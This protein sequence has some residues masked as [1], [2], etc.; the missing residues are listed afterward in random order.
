M[1]TTLP[2]Q[3]PS[4]QSNRQGAIRAG[5]YARV[6]TNDGR[7]DAEV[8]LS[9]LRTYSR[10]RGFAIQYEYIDHISGACEDRS[11][12]HQL[13]ADARQ[14]KLDAVLVW[15]FDRFARSTKALVLALEEFNTLG[16]DFVSYTEQID[17]TTPMGKAMFTMVSA[18]AEFERSLIRERV[19]AGLQRARE[20]GVKLGRPRVGFDMVKALQ[21]RSDGM[22][23]RN[24]A[25][26]LGISYTSVRRYLKGVS[27]TSLQ[28]PAYSVS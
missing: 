18:M 8:Q 25:K 6:S 27:K 20:R 17:T 21:L 23:L 7:Q 11:G 1:S 28:E 22:S 13:I 14:R 5:L 26:E 15:K 4:G 12:Y 16:V 2:D 9:Q 3:S 19:A 10:Q 24:I